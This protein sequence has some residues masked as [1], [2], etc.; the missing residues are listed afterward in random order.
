MLG[1]LVVLIIGSLVAIRLLPQMETIEKRQQETSFDQ[2]LSLIRQAVYLERQLGDLSPCK[3]QYNDLVADSQN[4]AKLEAYLNALVQFNFLTIDKHQ[5][6]LIAPHHW[7][8]GPGQIFWQ[9]TR[10]LVSSDTT[11]G[12]GSFEAGAEVSEG[13]SSPVG[14]INSMP[15]NDNATFAEGISMPDLDDFPWQNKFGNTAGQPGRSLR[16]ASYTP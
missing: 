13:F 6:P 3:V 4:S 12:I 2:T 7:G 15:Y 8:V 9:T 10:N 5:N 14:W 1:M 11:F 16:I